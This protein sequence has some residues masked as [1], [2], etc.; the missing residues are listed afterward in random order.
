VSIEQEV[1]RRITPSEE[2][3]REVEEAVSL[4]LQHIERERDR[5]GLDVGVRLV[6]SVAKGTFL[7][8]PDIDIFL[9]FPEGTDRRELEEKGLAVGRAVLGGEERYA[10]HPYIH[11]MY[12]GF[13]VDIV[14]CYDITDTSELRSAVDRTPFH[15]EFIRRRIQEWQRD[16]VRKVKQFMKGIGTYGADA[17]VQGF[18]GYLIELLVLRY[19]DFPEVLRAGANWSYGETLWL[20]EPGTEE[21]DDP[22]VFYDPVDPARNVASALSIDSFALFIHACREYLKEA[23]ISFFFP[24]P[25][26]VMTVEQVKRT[27]RER[28][29]SLLLL[30]FSRPDLIDDNLYPQ[31]RKSLE[32]VR[33]LLDGNDF[34]VIDATF[35]VHKSIRLIFEMRSLTLPLG[36]RHVGP[37]V[38]M[39]HGEDFL[40]K[41]REE[42]LSRPFIEKGRWMVIA[43]RKH[44]NLS[45]F[46]RERIGRAAMGSAF[47]DSE[48]R[49]LS[50]EDVINESNLDTI[51]RLLDRRMP[52]EW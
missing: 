11:G 17:K 25:R 51:T 24:R 34:E 14:P 4:L 6:G 16:E 48:A 50:G 46:L 49:V 12:R 43:P 7:P 18:S 2:Q 10:E 37:P 23:R 1:L 27:M 33:N 13:E 22:L 3:R 44:T 30:E 42:G 19:G 52:W 45:E 47:R 39:D 28:E 40:A 41:W 9:M 8:N 38:W 31:T 15:T 36:R 21:F 5:M 29:T 26:P 32:G 35:H 20:D